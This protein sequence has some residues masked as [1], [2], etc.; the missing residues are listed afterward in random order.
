M[1]DQS[2]KILG[3]ERRNL[4]LSW[5]RSSAHPLTGQSLASRTGVSRQVIVQDVSL[6]KAGGHPIIATARGYVYLPDQ[7]QMARQKRTIAVSH[8]PEDTAKEL[9]ILVDY[10]VMVENVTVEHP[11]YGDLTGSLMLR[12]RHDVNAF[13]EKVK[14]TKANLLLDLT[15]GVHMHTLEAD[16]EEQLDQAVE[17]LGKAGFLLES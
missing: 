10:G 4:I 16:T 8:K 3:V 12:N 1:R 15:E 2:D 6:L 5:L 13:L 17:A 7:A 14:T 9:Y 11:I